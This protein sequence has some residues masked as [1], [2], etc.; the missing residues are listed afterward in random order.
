MVKSNLNSG[1]DP[2]KVKA[3]QKARFADE[4]IV[5]QIMELDG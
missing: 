3:S 2:A 5:D 1:G 4:T